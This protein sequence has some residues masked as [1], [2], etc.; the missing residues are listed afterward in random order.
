MEN[1]WNKISGILIDITSENKL[2]ETELS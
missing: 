1:Y 2:N